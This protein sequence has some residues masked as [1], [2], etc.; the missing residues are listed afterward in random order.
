MNKK[1]QM[2]PEDFRNLI[3]FAVLSMLLWFVWETYITK[4]QKEKLQKAREARNELII[5]NPE[6]LEPITYVSRNDVLDT[7]KIKR[8]NFSNANIAGSILLE[9]ARLDDL[10]LKGYYEKLDGKNNVVLL[11]PEGTDRARY[12]EYGWYSPDKTLK[13]PDSRTVWSLQGNRELKPDAPLTLVWDNGQGLTF[14]RTIALDEHFG[15]TMDQSVTNNTAASVVVYP[16]ALI[17]QNGV[18]KDFTGR[19]T[20][21]EG[22]MGFMGGELVHA[23]Y[24]HLLTEQKISREAASGWLG[25]SDKYWLTAL[26]PPQGQLAKYRFHVAPDP[27]HPEM[28][29]YQTDITGEP[30][31]VGPGATVKKTVHA[32]MGTKK[33]SVLEDYEALLSVPNF[34]LAVDFGWFWF[35]TYPFY[36]ALHYLGLLTGNMGVAIIILTFFL[37]MAVYPLTRTTF[38]SFAKMRVVQPQILEIRNKFGNDKERLQQEIVELYRTNGVNP[39]SGCLPALVQIPIF[40]ALYKIILVTIELRHAPFFGWIQDLSDHDPTTLFNLFGL[41]PWTPPGFLMVGAWPCF[42]LAVLL[43]QKQLTPPPQDQVQRDMRNYFPFII[44]YIMAQFPAGLVVYWTFSGAISAM[45]Q[46]YI[47]KSLGVPIHLFEKNKTDAEM[48]KKVEE[49]PAAH[50]LIEM[51]EEDAEK[52]L[53]GD[54]GESAQQAQDNGEPPA[55]IKPP[56]PRKKKKK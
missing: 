14:E 2:H 55:P 20:A 35:F 50:P 10:V 5:K 40:F 29:R 11:H 42:M 48:E 39:L 32:Y 1:D 26:I 31:S 24:A 7:S 43:V 46:A 33:V 19:W 21:Y 53:F 37:R 8:V 28:N 23:D 49:G 56:K 54:E 9:G 16:F 17:V 30:V 4:P 47:M 44:T 45:Q 51:A 36:I 34:D 3:L 15:F 38:H 41:I 6:L 13:L 25:I 12:M 52:A 27:I 22:P 18:P